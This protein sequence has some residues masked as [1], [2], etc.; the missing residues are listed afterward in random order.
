MNDKTPHEVNMT[1]QIMK[2]YFRLGIPKCS[3]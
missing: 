1:Y 3:I 2:S